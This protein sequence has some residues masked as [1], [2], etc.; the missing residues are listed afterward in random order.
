MKSKL[1]VIVAGGIALLSLG[2]VYSVQQTEQAL[3][4]EFGQ[5]VGVVKEAGLHF[6]KPF[7][8]QTIITLDNRVL[9]LNADPREVIASDQ[10]RLIIDAFAKYKIIDPLK[11]YQT[12][13]DE[14]GARM[15]LNAILDS[16]L[17][18][19]VGN[20]PLSRL[21]SQERVAMMKTAQE[22]VNAEA[23]SFGVDVVD[24]RIMRADL[25]QENSQRIYN[26]MNTER[27]REAKEFRA[28]GAEEAQR[29][30][31][32]AEKERTILL[33]EA[34]RKSEQLHGEGDAQANSIV[35][36]VSSRDPEFFKFYRTINAYKNALPP[37]N[38]RL[39]LTPDSEFLKFMESERVR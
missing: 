19:T 34:Q 16:K 5:P 33:A 2:C 22:R 4:L 9:D 6:K 36:E 28:Q 29:I 38:T 31:A 25:P 35:A 12:V 10:K 15:R 24:V 23:A 32:K 14:R 20:F 37:E 30:M 27:D 1:L 18:E 8:F 7:L 21:L 26:R 11:F 17:R 39:V 3:V 13:R